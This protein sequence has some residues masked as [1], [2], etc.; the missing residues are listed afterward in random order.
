MTILQKLAVVFGICLILAWAT[1]S[2]FA[3]EGSMG[4]Y[5]HMI[6]RI[7]GAI[8][9]LAWFAVWWFSSDRSQKHK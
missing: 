2:H 9:A 1:I 6:F 5:A 4:Y 3:V 8:S 7:V